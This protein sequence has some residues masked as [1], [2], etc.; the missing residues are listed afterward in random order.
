MSNATDEF[1][2]WTRTIEKLKLEAN[3]LVVNSTQRMQK[4]SMEYENKLEEHTAT[5]E[6]VFNH[7]VNGLVQ[8]LGFHQQVTES[9]DLVKTVAAEE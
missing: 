2:H 8:V 5:K 4:L 9:L 3:E 7:V 6:K 1:S